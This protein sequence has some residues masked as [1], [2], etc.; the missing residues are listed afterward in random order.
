MLEQIVFKHILRNVSLHTAIMDVLG[1]YPDTYEEAA[2]H[3]EDAIT[4]HL[5]E[6]GLSD[7]AAELVAACITHLDTNHL[8]DLLE[9]E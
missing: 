3:L 9:N 1:M 5:V 6:D 2:L 8:I 4:D 7:F